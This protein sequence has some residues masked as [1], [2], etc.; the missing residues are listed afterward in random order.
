MDKVAVLWSVLHHLEF[1]Q[2]NPMQNAGS[3]SPLS[4]FWN[5]IVATL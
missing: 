4:R 3:R 2:K 1:L 5:T